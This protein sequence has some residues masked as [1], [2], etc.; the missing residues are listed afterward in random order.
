MKRT[1]GILMFLLLTVLGIGTLFGHRANSEIVFSNCQLVLEGNSVG[2]LF[3]HRANLESTDTQGLS[4]AEITVLKKGALADTKEYTGPQTVKKLMAAFDDTYN[5]NHSKTVVRVFRKV[6]NVTSGV[7]LLTSGD[8]NLPPKIDSAD[9]EVASSQ[10]TPTEI[11]ARYPRAAWLQLL[12]DKGITIENFHEYASYLSK[13]HTLAFLEDNPKL[14]K[15]VPLGIPATDN[16]NTYKAA[17]IDKLV[18]EHT[19]MRRVAAQVAKVKIQVENAKVQLER[20]KTQIERA[21]QHFNSQPLKDATKQ[22]ENVK[23][24]LENAREQLKNT[25]EQLER[26]RDVLERSK[27]PKRIVKTRKSYPPL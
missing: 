20:S 26:V 7:Y 18:K 4:F 3:G 2:T 11:E 6:G 9:R 21:K 22:L 10:L 19:K 13:R 5:N 8:V 15:S 27:R 17:Y 25:Q 23:K 12:L 16:W 24:Q 1:I 14:R